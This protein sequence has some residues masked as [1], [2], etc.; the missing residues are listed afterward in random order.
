M[1]AACYRDARNAEYRKNVEEMLDV[2]PDIRIPEY[3]FYIEY[4]EEY[5]DFYGEAFCRRYGSV[6]LRTAAGGRVPLSTRLGGGK[7]QLKVRLGNLVRK[8][9]NSAA[10]VS[11]SLACALLVTSLVACE[12]AEL[13]PEEALDALE[14][15]I[16]VEG[17]RISFT[18]TKPRTS[19]FR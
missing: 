16:A 2:D 19:K 9:R 15:S 3:D 4:Y 10:L 12:Q 6:L 1:A 7:G 17:D 14:D 5:L 13:T 11:I 18:V 8:K